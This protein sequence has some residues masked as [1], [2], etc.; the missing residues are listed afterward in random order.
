MLRVPEC[1]AERA[2][3]GPLLNSGLVGG[4]DL[5]RVL[6]M[7]AS[8]S[9]L[10]RRGAPQGHSRSSQSSPQTMNAREQIEQR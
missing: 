2:L 4:K 7:Y 10:K 9:Y 1:H 8:K 6:E 5:R 3:A